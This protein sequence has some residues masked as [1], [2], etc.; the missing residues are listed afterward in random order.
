MQPSKRI[1][2]VEDEAIIAEYLRDVLEHLHYE[3]VG[4]ATRASEALQWMRQHPPDLLLLDVMLQG[5]LDGVDLAHRLRSEYRVPFVFLTSLSNAATVTRIKETRP[6]GYL[7]KPFEEHDIYVALEM[8]FANFAAE[9]AVAMPPVP[10]VAAVPAPTALY[11]RDRGR[12]VKVE[13]RDLLWLEADGNYTALHTRANKIMI[14]TPLKQ[15]EE[16]LAEADFVRIH[17]SYVVAIHSIAAVDAQHIIM[18][19]SNVSLPIGRAYRADLFHRLR[20][21]G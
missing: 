5:E 19:P 14:S 9:Q 10:S 7:V 13:F 17:R 15:V 12:H 2:I 20:L 21:L 6:H 1:L 8:A 11:V 18:A 16:K 3:V 4:V